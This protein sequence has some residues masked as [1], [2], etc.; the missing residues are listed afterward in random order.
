[1]TDKI[2]ERK[3]ELEKE[4]EDEISVAMPLTPKYRIFY[5]SR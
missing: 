2:A 1:M 3:K 5:F 4:T